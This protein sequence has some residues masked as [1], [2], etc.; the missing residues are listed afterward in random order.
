[1]VPDGE[2]T[3]KPETLLISPILLEITWM[4]PRLRW[5]AAAWLQVEF[6]KHFTLSDIKLLF[7]PWMGTPLTCKINVFAANLQVWHCEDAP[8]LHWNMGGH[9][10][11]GANRVNMY[12]LPKLNTHS[13]LLG[14]SPYHGIFRITRSLLFCLVDWAQPISYISAVILE[15]FKILTGELQNDWWKTYFYTT[16]HPVSTGFYLRRFNPIPSSLILS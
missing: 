16:P 3:Y 5:S 2:T 8:R 9:C 10:N 11:L 12:R 14:S 4:A 13:N 1:M 15:Q 7:W 6:I